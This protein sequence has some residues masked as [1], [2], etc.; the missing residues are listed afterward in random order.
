MMATFLDLIQQSPKGSILKEIEELI[1]WSRI[2][3]KL[4]HLMLSGK[5]GRPSYAPLKMFKILL[6]QRLY[7]LSDPEME[8]QLY[9]R[10]SFRSFCGFGM[11]DSLPDETTICRFRN[12]ILGKVETLFNLVLD[13]LE[14]KGL[15]LRK[16][17]L[18]DATI[19]KANVKNPSGGTQSEVDPQAGW[20]KKNDTYTYGYKAHVGVDEESGLVV[21]AVI[22]SADFHDSQV[23]HHVVSGEEQAVYADKAYDSR[24]IR[25]LLQ[26]NGIKD[27]ILYKKSKGKD[28]Q[29][30]KKLLNKLYSKVRCGV[31][32]VFAHWKGQH[33]YTKARYRG[34]DKN[35]LHLDLLCM[36][37]NIKRA[38]SI[39][40]KQNLMVNCV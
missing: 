19:I 34:W 10:L 7:D 4:K 21:K 36:V 31:E 29:P 1:D 6:L 38:C 8:H 30:R 25:E 13:Q 9:D 5:M 16:G 18:V 15:L 35:Q 22:T 40:K 12:G 20:T 2:D 23:I 17:T 37:Y 11:A 3:Q 28:L 14:Q 27:R 26:E 39:L 24:A 32:R 33:G